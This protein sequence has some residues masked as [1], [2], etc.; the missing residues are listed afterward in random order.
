VATSPSLD[1]SP[2][3]RFEDGEKPDL[4]PT[5]RKPG[6]T[7]SIVFRQGF[8]VFLLSARLSMDVSRET[9][10]AYSRGNQPW[11]FALLPNAGPVA[12]FSARLLRILKTAGKTTNF[13]P[14]HSLFGRCYRSQFLSLSDRSFIRFGWLFL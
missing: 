8:A 2:F 6:L 1:L 14:R 5:R 13:E 4:Q 11:P 12:S 9:E 3:K 7:S 10:V